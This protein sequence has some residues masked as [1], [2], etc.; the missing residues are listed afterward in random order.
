METHTLNGHEILILYYICM[1]EFVCSSK[2]MNKKQIKRKKENV[3]NGTGRRTEWLAESPWMGGFLAS[4]NVAVGGLLGN[5]VYFLCSPS[6]SFTD[7]G[8]FP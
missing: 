7:L 8:Y 5:L 6:D 4:L 3:L 2:Q 1:V